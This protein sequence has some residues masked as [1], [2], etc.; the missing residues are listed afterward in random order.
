[1]AA[2]SVW[3]GFRAA[4][5]VAVGW[6]AV[7][8]GT[9]VAEG[10]KADAPAKAEAA[11]AD[12][13]VDEAVKLNSVTGEDAMRGRLVDLVADKN[14]EKTKALVAAAAAKLKAS[15]G[16]DVPFNY[17]ASLILAK[18]AHALKENGPAEA[19]Y[20]Y[21]AEQAL[22]LQSTNKIVQSYEGLIDL[23]WDVKKFNAVEEVCQKFMELR[24]RDEKVQEQIDQ[25]RPFI[26]E[27]MVQAKAK[28]GQT[29][30]AL[31]I[32]EGLIQIDEGGWY[33]T[34]L[35]GWVQ[36][37]AGKTD[38]AIDTYKEVIEK[39][40][41]AKNLKPDAKERFQDG[42]RYLLSGLYVDV[43][44]IDKAAEQLQ[45]LVKKHPNNATYANDLGFIWADNDRNLDEAEALVRKALD[46]D[47][48]AR[49]KLKEEG[50]LIDDSDNAA[51]LDSLGW[52]L[53]KKKQYAEAAK[54]LE[55][56]AKDEDEGQHI[57]IFDHLADCYAALGDKK[58]AVETWEKALKLDDVSKRDAERRRKV[59]EKLKKARAEVK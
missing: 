22:R 59:T 47:K 49:A 37:E 32:T 25:A 5:L 36:R 14:K 3:G 52:V 56:A 10:K 30:E 57:E 19:F 35:K 11:A 41:K 18:A 58:K 43:K 42:I 55:Q 33:F 15:K 2:A 9:A 31:R 44:N 53:F 39:L 16:K 12:P 46:E 28:Q 7:A 4:G 6:L 50:R 54:Y 23:Y 17:N 27:K 21:C 8:A 38:D 13:L 24:S 51:Y 34:Q 20:E 26:L 40:G 29:D 1:M 45:A 48:K